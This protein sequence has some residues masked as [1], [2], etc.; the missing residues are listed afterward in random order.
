MNL[1]KFLKYNTKLRLLRGG[2][3]KIIMDKIIMDKTYIDKNIN[4]LKNINKN[5]LED[6]KIMKNNI[7][8]HIFSNTN[9]QYDISEE[10][11]K[12]IDK[13]KNELKNIHNNEAFN[14]NLIDIAEKT[15][16]FYIDSAYSMN[17]YVSDKIND[18]NKK[19]DENKNKINDE[20]KNKINIISNTNNDIDN[21]KN[22]YIHDISVEEYDLN[23]GNY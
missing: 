10:N 17:T 13:M 11:K 2:A 19:N 8:T 9:Y 20:N 18:K 3:E 21:D 6:I 12:I 5:I 22:N 7:N 16:R 15:N 4:D 14:N 1:E 23:K